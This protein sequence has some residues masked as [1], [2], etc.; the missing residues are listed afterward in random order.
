MGSTICTVVYGKVDSFFSFP[1][2]LGLYGYRYSASAEAD[3]P[4]IPK[5][6]V[7]AVSVVAAISTYIASRSEFCRLRL[8]WLSS[9]YTNFPFDSDHVSVDPR[10][11]PFSPGA[12]FFGPPKEIA[13]TPPV[14]VDCCS[15]DSSAEDDSFVASLSESVPLLLEV[16]GRYHC[17]NVICRLRCFLWSSGFS[18]FLIPLQF[19]PYLNPIFYIVRRERTQKRL[20][21]SYRL[22][23]IDSFFVTSF[24]MSFDCS[25]MW[26]VSPS[27][28]F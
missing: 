10:F 23:T 20:R 26:L 22:E 1:L 11:D 12:I 9:K 15:Y 5:F 19:P 24:T 18:S 3:S 6:P 7:S 8:C 2:H 21:G 13:Q 28:V 14:A 4:V 25:S 17:G 27:T 16:G